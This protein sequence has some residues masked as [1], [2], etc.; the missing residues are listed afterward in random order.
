MTVSAARM[1]PHT[2]S[3]TRERSHALS[4]GARRLAEAAAVLA[5]AGCAA[6]YE[7][8]PRAHFDGKV[9]SNPGVVKESSVLGYLWLRVR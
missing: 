9:F 8:P 5:L 6:P 4:R 3:R 2:G 7:G 1:H